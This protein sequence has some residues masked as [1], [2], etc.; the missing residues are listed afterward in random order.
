MAPAPHEPPVSPPGTPGPA[1]TSA[2]TPEPPRSPCPGVPA[3]PVGHG[4]GAPVPPRVPPRSRPSSRPLVP[5]GPRGPFPTPPGWPLVVLAGAEPSGPS[6]GS[7]GAAAAPRPAPNPPRPAP[8]PP[9][10]GTAPGPLRSRGS[11]RE[12]RAGPKSCW[13]PPVPSPRDWG[14]PHARDEFGRSQLGAAPA[15]PGPG[16][17]PLSRC[18]RIPG[19][20]RTPPSRHSRLPTHI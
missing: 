2:A 17:A 7:T 14:H 5:P 8:N 1:V 15:I 19:G 13:V 6:W 18:S 20:I 12:S 10:P 4:E 11:K 9:G 16:A 3:A